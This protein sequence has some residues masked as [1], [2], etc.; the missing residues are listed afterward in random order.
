MLPFQDSKKSWLTHNA[1][2]HVTMLDAVDGTLQATA[3]FQLSDFFQKAIEVL[4]RCILSVVLHLSGFKLHPSPT[5]V[6]ALFCSSGIS[7]LSVLI[8]Q[9]LLE[10]THIPSITWQ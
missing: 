2:V 7:W 3:R 1:V 9:I 8:I 6:D 10:V 4:F 5:P